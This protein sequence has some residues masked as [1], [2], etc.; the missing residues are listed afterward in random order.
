M[1]KSKV[2]YR[3]CGAMIAALM[4]ICWS[5]ISMAAE[6]IY[7]AGTP[8][9]WPLEYYD[10]ESNTYH[11]IIPDLLRE[12]G[13][14][15]G[16]KV[17]YI[18]P[19]KEDRR[20]ELAENVQVDMICT[21]GLDASR[22][23]QTGLEEGSAFLTYLEEGA[24]KA[25]ALSYTKGITASEKERL[26]KA[27]QGLDQAQIQGL[28][29]S[30]A[31]MEKSDN[32]FWE[33]YDFVILAAFGI[34][35]ILLL[36]VS[37]G[38]SRKKKR[39][40]LLAYQDDVTGKSNFADW[41]RKWDKVIVDEN[42]ELY[43]VTFLT[44]GIDM[45]SH[46][47]G[48]D[49]ASCAMKLLSDVCAEWIMPE[50][51]NFA[52]FNEYYFVFHL[53]FTN[54]QVL[55]VRINSL[56]ERLEQRFREEKKKYFLELHMGIYRLTAM[57]KDPLKTVQYSEVAAM[58]AKSHYLGAAVYNEMV[59]KETISS[60]S[61]E[62]EAI[63]GLMRQEFI[64]YLQ[65]VMEINTGRIY[66][67]E[68]LVRWQNPDRGLLNPADFLYVMKE[69]QLLGKMDMEIFRQGCRFLQS[70]QN[71]GNDFYLMFNFTKENL[72]HDEFAEVLMV[73][74]EQFRV[75]PERILLQLNLADANTESEAY[76]NT[77]RRLA[78]YKFEIWLAGI[79][80]DHSFF[81]YMEY[82]IS[83]IKLGHEL[84]GQ[85]GCPEGRKVV[86]SIIT[87]C[88]D[89]K[90]KVMCVGAEDETQVQILKQLGC[91]LVSGMYFY[92]PVTP[93]GFAE[94]IEPA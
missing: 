79:Q 25:V 19:S 78:G 28:F 42:R 30:Y 77:I 54:D 22:L 49:E 33:K 29:L 92:Y 34:A 12:A 36:V 23:S 62:H 52:R 94:I 37:L 24:E 88:G 61:M 56:Y 7:I 41:K 93:E 18:Q 63:N 82:G 17:T 67:A 15:A 57:D 27:L 90:L 21:L 64:L 76:W 8:D 58:F 46:I 44:G 71:R 40:E 89:L 72:I 5:T 32:Y 80:L 59:E 51:E 47:Y 86:E 74:A 65:P 38:F 55:Q 83:G 43:A 66:G 14:T 26:E 48:Y 31:R 2:L 16:L 60:Y 69:K 13:K 84:I 20:L 85:I 53:Q 81:K 73:T 9:A 75:K 50:K 35:V 91:E 11:G 1:K 3:I 39:I 87:L 6:E 68:A 45:I 10:K 70:E 4:L